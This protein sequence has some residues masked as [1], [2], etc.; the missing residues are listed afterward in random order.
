M[1]DFTSVDNANMDYLPG[2]GD[3]SRVDAAAIDT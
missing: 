3:F 2:V 1:R